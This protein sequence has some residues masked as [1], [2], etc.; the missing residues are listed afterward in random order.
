M[1]PGWAGDH[2]TSLRIGRYG[3]YI[4][5]M[6]AHVEKNMFITIF[7]GGINHPKW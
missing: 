6:S 1:I 5:L 2:V 7:R 4:C 3:K